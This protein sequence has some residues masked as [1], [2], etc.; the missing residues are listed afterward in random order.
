M[1]GDSFFVSPG[2]CFKTLQR[3]SHNIDIKLERIFI[4][5]FL[6]VV[7]V[8]KRTEIF[9]ICKIIFLFLIKIPKKRSIR[10]IHLLSCY[11]NYCYCYYLMSFILKIKYYIRE[12]LLKIRMFLDN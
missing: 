2:S 12:M 9:T 10:F 5:K 8:I 6:D 4:H 11:F 7:L 1:S 3:V